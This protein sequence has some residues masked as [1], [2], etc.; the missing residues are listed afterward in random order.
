MKP[1]GAQ[2]LV[3]LVFGAILLS[4]GAIQLAQELPRGQV[5]QVFEL[6]TRLPSAANLRAYEQ[7]LEDESRLAGW[8]RPWMQ[9]AQFLL[10]RDLGEKAL[11]GRNGWYFYKPGVE[12]LTRRHALPPTAEDPVAAIVD[13]R[14]R[15]ATRGIHLVVLPA[16]NKESIY[17]EQ[18]M[19]WTSALSPAPGEPT[20]TFLRRL[21]SANVDVVDL[22]DLFVREKATTTRT[23]DS[24]LYLAQDSHWSPAGVEAAARAVAQHLVQTG[25]IERGVTDYQTRTAPTAR[26]GDV[27]R[28]LNVPQIETHTAA[29][30]VP[31]VQVIE[32]ATGQ[33]Y[34]DDPSSE[35]L[36]LG[37]SFLRIYEQDEPGAAGFVAHLAKE[38][39]QPV[40]SLISEGGASTLVR[41]ELHRR[42]TWL[43][44]KRVVVWEFVER[45]LRLGTEGWQRVPLPDE[46]TGGRAKPIASA[47]RGPAGVGGV[48]E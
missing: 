6:F 46:P 30:Q 9:Y 31:A 15:L 1:R 39:K 19:R 18:L 37:D 17:P 33:P 43:R 42:P 2:L 45:D 5:P 23:S 48:D 40:T 7:R 26:L 3:T 35:I 4:A 22:F 25:G 32:A 47:V 10:L 14:D 12:F 24:P 29:E 36:V 13:F 38:L 34:R 8:L 44:N 20:R 41:Q 27:L 16:P 21:R 11:A 28:M